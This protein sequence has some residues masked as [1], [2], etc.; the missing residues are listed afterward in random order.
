MEAESFRSRV[1]ALIQKSRRA[2]RLYS[3]SSGQPLARVEGSTAELAAAQVA[4]WREI[5]G[6]LLRRL[7]EAADSPS[8]KKLVYDVFALRN[9]FQALWRTSESELVQQ[10]RD[11]VSASERGD[12]IKATG[13]A[14]SLV[15]L[16]AR[17]QAGQAAHHELDLLIKRSRVVRPA[18]DLSEDGATVLSTIELL[19]E[20][21][22]NEDDA[23]T[24]RASS[25]LSGYQGAMVDE[26]PAKAVAGGGK[27][28]PLKRRD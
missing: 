28:I 17:V 13:L 8:T 15:S 18:A 11:L 3:H 14:A 12:F 10:Q 16:K 24:A 19:D 20:Q 22:V 5:N 26:L 4:E 7:S 6:L 21:S 23:V 9:E 1:V 2:L 27:V 25:G